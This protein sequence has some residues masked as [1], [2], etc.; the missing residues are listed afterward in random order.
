MPAT[1]VFEGDFSYGA[2]TGLSGAR[3][4]SLSIFANRSHLRSALRDDAVGAGLRVLAAGPL[5]D[6]LDAP[7]RPLGDVALI[8][9]PQVDART[10]AALA[11]LDQRAACCGTRLIVS[12]TIESLDPVFACMDQSMPTLLIDPN[13]AERVLALGRVL[14]EFPAA[15]L[16]ELSE[17]DRLMLLRLHEQ[18]NQIS[19]RMER[20][21]PRAQHEDPVSA[22]PFPAAAPS[23]DAPRDRGIQRGARPPLPD[24]K[25]IRGLIRQRQLR[26]RF[27]EGEL[28]SDPAWDMLLDLTAARVEQKRVSVTSLCIASGVPPTTALRWIGQMVEAGLFFRVCDDSDRRRAF[29]ELTDKAIG[30]MACYFA[31]LPL[32]APV[33]V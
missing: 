2:S 26:A 27:F 5:Q 8:D 4:V 25:L 28:F 18:I 7:S 19:D 23:H 33:P 14:A 29:I 24:A 12:T 30:A 31:E 16:R 15:R 17:D 21:V 6:L 9:C 3:S 11:D 10:V 13:R 20:L 32:T 1:D 22:F